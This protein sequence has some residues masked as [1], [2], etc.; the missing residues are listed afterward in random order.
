MAFVHGS[1]TAIL[2]GAY[3]L[4]TYFTNTDSDATVASHDVTTYTKNTV[5]RGAGLKDGKATISGF[6]DATADTILA[7]LLANASGA[8]LSICNG[9]ATRGNHAVIGQVMATSYKSSPPVG[10]YIAASLALECRTEYEPGGVI[11][12]T[13]EAEAATG[14]ETSVDNAVSSANGG[15]GVIHCTAIGTS[16][17]VKLQHSTNNTDWVD[18]SPAFAAL[19]AIGSEVIT[20]AAGIT[21][22]RYLRVYHT[23][24][25]SST[26]L[27]AFARR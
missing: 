19:S 13:L 5:Q 27:A 18:L 22:N 10:G 12:H 15:L 17:T 2:I 11:L 25:G 1:D 20:V 6:H 4:S 9:G 3:D 7:A 14:G 26:Y 21:I 23:C 8:A 24:T 16:L